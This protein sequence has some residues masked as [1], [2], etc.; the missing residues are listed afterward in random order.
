MICSGFL[1]LLGFL[2]ETTS[3]GF[4]LSFL[5]NFLA[6][7]ALFNFQS[8]WLLAS[9]FTS[10]YPQGVQLLKNEVVFPQSCTAGAALAGS[11]LKNSSQIPWNW[12]HYH[13]LHRNERNNLVFKPEGPEVRKHSD[14]MTLS[15]IKQAESKT[16][17]SSFLGLN[18]PNS[19]CTIK[20][21]LPTTT[22]WGQRKFRVAPGVILAPLI[23]ITFQRRRGGGARAGTQCKGTSCLRPRPPLAITWWHQTSSSTSVSLKSST[24]KCRPSVISWLIMLFNS[25]SILLHAEPPHVSWLCSICIFKAWQPRFSTWNRKLSNTSAKK[26][27]P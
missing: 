6:E 4:S 12:I 25:V 3:K 1:I 24:L 22:V 5:S 10:W 23:W 11:E 13:N 21:A 27:G 17:L 8:F 2:E 9:I 19:K 7:A 14:I 15:A 18:W 20:Q 16:G 26:Q